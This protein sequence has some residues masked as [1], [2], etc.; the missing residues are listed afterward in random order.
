VS[1]KISKRYAVV[2][3]RCGREF[4]AP[5]AASAM[6]ARIEAASRKGWHHDQRSKWGKGSKGDGQR[7]FD[8]CDRCED[9]R[10]GPDGGAQ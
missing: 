1:I 6:A 10:P 5:D 7:A 4:D 8:W 9:P 2:C 3:D